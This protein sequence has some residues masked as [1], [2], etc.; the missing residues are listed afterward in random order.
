MEH[1]KSRPIKTVAETTSSAEAVDRRL[2]TGWHNLGFTIQATT[3]SQFSKGYKLAAV[4]GT[5]SY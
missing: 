4:Y 5:I 1:D 2:L 3:N